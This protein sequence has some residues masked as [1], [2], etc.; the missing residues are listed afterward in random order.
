MFSTIL[1][2]DGRPL[3]M[4]EH[5]EHI[6]IEQEI[7]QDMLTGEL[8]RHYR[9]ADRPNWGEAPHWL[10]KEEA[11]EAGFTVTETWMPGDL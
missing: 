1:G 2:L 11:F 8:T 4:P 9:R 5:R 3:E 10:T 7:W 6:L